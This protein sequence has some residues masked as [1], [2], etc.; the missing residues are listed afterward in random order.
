MKIHVPMLFKIDTLLSF[1]FIFEVPQ[2]LILVYDLSKDSRV[3]L[4]PVDTQ[5]T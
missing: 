4:P 1:T 3:T 2:K 5:L